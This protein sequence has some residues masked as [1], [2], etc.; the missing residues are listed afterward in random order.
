[1]TTPLIIL[2]IL[3]IFSGLINVPGLFGG[4]QWLG[5][6]TGLVHFMENGNHLSEWITM[7]I[8]VLAVTGMIL[9]ARNMFSKKEIDQVSSTIL[10]PIGRLL[11]GKYY[12]DEI[13]QTVITNP[14]ARISD[15]LYSVVEIKI[16]DAL[17]EGVG[18]TVSY[19][20][21]IFRLLQ[22]GSVSFYLFFMVVGI[23]LVLVLNLFT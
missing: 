18:T 23:I 21:R 16:V 19:L 9:L 10:K 13:Y 15:K 8:T 12:V 17:V 3:S 4:G 14:L 5:N 22:S 1:M 7:I 20:S 6:Y 2:A 11:T